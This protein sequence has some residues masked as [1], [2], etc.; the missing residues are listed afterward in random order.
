[1]AT[2]GNQG[3]SAQTEIEARMLA[4]YWE[5]GRATGYWAH[6]YLATVRRHGGLAY[7]R[8]LLARRKMGE[9]LYR[10][11]F[12]GRLDLSVEWLVLNPRYGAVFSD[13]ERQTAYDRLEMVQGVFAAHKQEE[14][15]S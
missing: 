4:L 7:A 8:M 15:A 6:R 2:Q 3:L 12:A 5:A 11:A 1:M 13:A 9:G 14:T 10:W